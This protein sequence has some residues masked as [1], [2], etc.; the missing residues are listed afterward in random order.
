MTFF[1]VRWCRDQPTRPKMRE[2]DSTG[3]CEPY[4]LSTCTVV[5]NMTIY[6][7]CFPS[8]RV[9]HQHGLHY[10]NSGTLQSYSRVLANNVPKHANYQPILPGQSIPRQTEPPKGYTVIQ[11][12][13]AHRCLPQMGVQGHNRRRPDGPCYGLYQ[14]EGRQ[15]GGMQAGCKGVGAH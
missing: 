14:Y 3:G 2:I 13:R 5:Y 1:R 7:L 15:R 10:R 6:F 9:P 8:N 4:L 11:M 12:R